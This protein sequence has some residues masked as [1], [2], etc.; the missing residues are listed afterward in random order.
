MG[1]RTSADI[2]RTVAQPIVNLAFHR[3]WND[4]LGRIVIRSW[5][6]L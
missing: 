2:L 6:A 5:E 3:K 4:Q 1:N